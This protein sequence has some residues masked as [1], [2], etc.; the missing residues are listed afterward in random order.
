MVTTAI[1]Y[2]NIASPFDKPWDLFQKANQELWLIT[3]KVASNI[4]LF[5]ISIATA[6][7]FLKLL[8]DKSE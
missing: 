1:V 4:V 7:T 3:L 8:K 5:D 6:K 2:N